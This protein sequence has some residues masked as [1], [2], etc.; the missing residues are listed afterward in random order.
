MPLRSLEEVPESR[1]PA[2]L[3]PPAV[4]ARRHASTL[5]HR[6]ADM[7]AADD[8]R[9]DLAESKR[10]L[11]CSAQPHHHIPREAH[12]SMELRLEDP[13]LIAVRTEPLVPVLEVGR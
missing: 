12:E 4:R 5:R 13:L 7:V 6:G 1:G 3:H 11:S 10:R 2:W 9:S 8:R